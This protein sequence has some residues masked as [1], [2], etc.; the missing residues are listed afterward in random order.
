MHLALRKHCVLSF[1]SPHIINRDD[2][3]VLPGSRGYVGC[4]AG[5]NGGNKRRVPVV[6]AITCASRDL[7]LS[8]IQRALI[9]LTQRAIGVTQRALSITVILSSA[10][11]TE[12]DW[13]ACVVDRALGCGRQEVLPSGAL[14][15]A[16]DA[17]GEGL[18]LEAGWPHMGDP[19]RGA[20]SRMVR[21]WPEAPRRRYVGRVGLGL[22]A[23][24]YARS[25]CDSPASLPHALPSG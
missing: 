19:S 9:T 5:G 21:S 1:R 14:Q 17:D 2:D 7:A 10:Q 4:S 8:V 15:A 6:G 22:A 13:L 23:R 11:R 3:V 12:S 24:E 18:G 16:G 25:C 20:S